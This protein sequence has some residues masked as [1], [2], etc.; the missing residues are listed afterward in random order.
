MVINWEGLL[1]ILMDK[2]LFF[3]RNPS[4]TIF[5]NWETRGS[6]NPL[7]FSNPNGLSI[8]PNCFQV[9]ISAISSN[10]PMPPGNTTNKSANQPC[11]S[12][13]RAW[14]LRQSVQ[15]GHGEQPR[16]APENQE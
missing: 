2:R 5:S 11:V 15:K 6:K 4:F 7:T 1:A 3:L 10:V 12:C 16:A 13:A 8:N 9:R 14:F